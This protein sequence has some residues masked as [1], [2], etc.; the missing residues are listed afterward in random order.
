[1]RDCEQQFIFGTLV[2]KTMRYK[3]LII[4][5]NH[6]F[7]TPMLSVFNVECTPNMDSN[8]IVWNNVDCMDTGANIWYCYLI[9]LL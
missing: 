6:Y 7:M 4:I 1:M 3:F 9:P 2:M 8:E 5:M